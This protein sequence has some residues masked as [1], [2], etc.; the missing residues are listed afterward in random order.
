MRGEIGVFDGKSYQPDNDQVT[1]LV[2]PVKAVNVSMSDLPRGGRRRRYYGGLHC[3][4]IGDFVDALLRNC[5]P[6]VDIAPRP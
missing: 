3:L 5:C 1:E 4:L 2:E 6:T